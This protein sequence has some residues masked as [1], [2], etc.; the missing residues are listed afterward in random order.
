MARIENSTCLK[1]GEYQDWVNG[2]EM[3]SCPKCSAEINAIKACGILAQ[4]NYKERRELFQKVALAM[5]PAYINRQIGWTGTFLENVAKET[6]AFL[7]E[8]QKFA[9][10]QPSK[11]EGES[12]RRSII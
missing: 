8:S 7:E 9:E 12:E 2:S 4:D 6:E 5:L 10:Q 11:S 3:P 1:H